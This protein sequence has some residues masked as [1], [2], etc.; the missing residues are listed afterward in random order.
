MGG[1]VSPVGDSYGKQGLVLAKHRVAMAELALQS[2]NWV[3]VDGWESQQPDWTE[4]VVTMRYKPS[5][6]LEFSFKITF[7]KNL[8]ISGMKRSGCNN[9]AFSFLSAFMN[10][11]R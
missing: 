10:A 3:T 5:L 2:S 9:L 1:I 7:E 4:T 11:P 8:T 6:M